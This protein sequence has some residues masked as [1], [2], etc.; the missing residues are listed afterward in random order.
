MPSSAQFSTSAKPIVMFIHGFLDGA[1]AWND[2]VDVLRPDV[3]ARAVDLAGMGTRA[4]ETGPFSLERF[5]LDVGLALDSI[6]QPV[7]LVGHS[8]GAQVAEIV[9]ARH[10]SLVRGLVL[11]TPVA[12][13]GTPLPEEAQASFRALGGQPAAQRELRQRLSVSLSANG[14]ERLG[15]LGDRPSPAAASAFFD[16]W[17]HGHPDGAHPTRYPGPVLIVSGEGDPFVDAAMIV[18][19]IAPRFDKATRATIPQ[20]GHWP[21]VEQPALLARVLADFLQQLTHST[22]PGSAPSGWTGAFASKSVQAFSD[23]FAPGIVL[24]ASVL[25]RPVVGREAVKTVMG[26]ASG[27]YESVKFTHET[28]DGQRT[29]LEW[30]AAAFGGMELRGVTI[31]TKD[32]EGRIVRAAIHHRPLGAA[33]RFSSELG[34]RLGEAFPADHFHAAA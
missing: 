26:T 9:A 20:A 17:S 10:P 3:D 18:S 22:A 11:L 12:L 28:T 4:G 27:I 15:A 2:V 1:A 5:A 31:L 30:V 33:L 34:K 24:E 21:Q 29:Y 13:A 25:A 23:A 16:A 14:L 7:V 32:E 19:A 8:M 6:G